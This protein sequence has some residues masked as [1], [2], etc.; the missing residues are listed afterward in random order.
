MGCPL[1]I[2]STYRKG[3]GEAPDAIRMASESIET[4]SPLL[5]KDLSDSPF[6]DLGDLT[7][8]GQSL[9]SALDIIQAAVGEILEKGATPMC[10]GGEHTLT[11]ATVQAFRRRHREFAVV[12]LDAHSDLR[13]DYEGNS[14]NHTTVIGPRV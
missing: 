7:L 2:T 3:T 10:L 5:D 14:I 12:H 11:L 8:T 9:E 13:D 4:Y 6:S 1:D